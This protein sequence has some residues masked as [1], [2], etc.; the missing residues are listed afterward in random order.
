MKSSC[1]VSLVGLS[2]MAYFY[3]VWDPLCVSRDQ[4]FLTCQ[5]NGLCPAFVFD[6]VDARC[7][8]ALTLW[9]IV[10]SK[11]RAT[12]WDEQG[13]DIDFLSFHIRRDGLSQLPIIVN[14][15]ETQTP[16]T[17]GSST[18]FRDVFVHRPVNDI[19]QVDNGWL[20][21]PYP[22]MTDDNSTVPPHITMHVSSLSPRST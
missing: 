12:M 16:Q 4:Y 19:L 8:R 10:H 2:L 3:L 14:I 9:E 20:S 5:P 18:Y 6:S 7:T 22:Q 21:E 17:I 11:D 1:G 15:F 13:D